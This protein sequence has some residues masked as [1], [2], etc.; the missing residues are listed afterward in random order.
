MNHYQTTLQQSVVYSG[1][2][3]HLGKETSIHF[4]PAPANTGIVFVRT[5]VKSKPRIEAC[6]ANVRQ[7]EEQSRRTT[8]GY[9]YYEV[10]TVEHVLSALYGLGIDNCIIELDSDEPPE[11]E[12]GSIRSYIEVLEKGG[13]NEIEGK[14]SRVIKIDKPVS[15]DAFGA[16]LAVALTAQIA[17]PS[18]CGA[19]R[20][21]NPGRQFAVCL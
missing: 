4:L 20:L 13:K 10:H 15:I 2:G 16:S 5:D 6:L 18:R 1:V 17:R 11:P 7:V 19:I 21:S 14:L 8:L 12:D 3:L 9:D